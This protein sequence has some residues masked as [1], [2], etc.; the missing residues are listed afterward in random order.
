M[1]DRRPTGPRSMGDLLARQ[2][3]RDDTLAELVEQTHPTPTDGV[4]VTS[5]PEGQAATALARDPDK[6]RDGSEMP[7]SRFRAIAGSGS[8]SPRT[9]ESARSRISKVDC[10]PPPPPPPRGRGPMNCCSTSTHYRLLDP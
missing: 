4:T 8:I 5:T 9:D 3:T 1:T 7:T 10:S 6:R 2:R